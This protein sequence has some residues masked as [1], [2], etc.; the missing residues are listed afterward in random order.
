MK[1][2]LVPAM[3]AAALLSGAAPAAAVTP[4]P[5]PAASTSFN[6]GSLHVDVYGTAGKPA[7][8]FIPGLT[9]G[10]WEWS[11]QIALFAPDY[12]IYALTLPGFDG[13]AAISTPPFATVSA[14]FWKM[15]A[16]QH[17]DKPV[18]IGHSLGGTTGILL[19]EQHSNLLR[20]VIAVDG[21]P[22]L[23]GL[24]KMTPAQR[25]TAA[26]QMQTMMG[27]ASTPAA[28]E[29]AEKTYVLPYLM[30]SPQDVAAV[31][32]LVSRSDPAGTSAWLA[33]DMEQDLRPGL[34]A[35]TVPLFEI[36]PFDPTL[37]PRNPQSPFATSADK[38]AYYTSLL[39]GDATAKVQMVP[40]SRHFI[41]YDQPQA[42]DALLQSD[43][44]AM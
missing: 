38:Q 37:D 10:P 7:L 17:I 43:L 34:T 36:A 28:F 42:L 40:N 5:L 27:A 11:R 2:F 8:V 24:D 30:T 1:R 12:R 25:Q 44:K 26:T 35:I 20:G 18:V 14:D 22:L 3:M 32:P 21:L 16:A 39:A 41:M 33:A 15:L 9:C 19:A 23:P 6:A 29:S 13:L 31:A 4:P